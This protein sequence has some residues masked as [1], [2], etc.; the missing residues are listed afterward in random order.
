MEIEERRCGPGPRRVDRCRTGR[1]NGLD[2]GGVRIQ[3]TARVRIRARAFAQH[4]EGAEREIGFAGAA[5]ECLGDVAADDELAAHDAHRAAQRQPHHRLAQAPLE[6]AEP[7]ARIAADLRGQLDEA[8]RQHQPPG[9]GIHEQR[10]RA[11]GVCRP[12]AAGELLGDQPVGGLIVRDAQQRF[13]EAHERDAFLVRETELLQ[14][15][16]EV[17]ALGGARA[18]ARDEGAAD[19]QRG[20]P[21]SRVHDR[22]ERA[23]GAGLVAVR[24]GLEGIEWQH[25]IGLPYS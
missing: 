14:E 24:G 10:V 11:A 16:V 8:P 4:V 19:A 1:G 6:R 7:A 22:L 12:V 15:A 2:G 13:G 21:R 18:R 23:H 25:G 20:G 17:G 9:R 3:V 5:L